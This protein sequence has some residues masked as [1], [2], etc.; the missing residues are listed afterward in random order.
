MPTA[1]PSTTTN[2]FGIFYSVFFLRKKNM[3]TNHVVNTAR[4]DAINTSSRCVTLSVA[5]DKNIVSDIFICPS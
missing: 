2:N 1:T 3:A 5:G 4:P